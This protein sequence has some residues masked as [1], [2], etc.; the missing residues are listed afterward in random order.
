MRIYLATQRF[1]YQRLTVLT[2]QWSQNNLKEPLIWGN[3]NKCTL[4]RQN[5]TNV[6]QEIRS[7]FMMLPCKTMQLISLNKSDGQR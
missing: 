3:L 4:F 1:H 6:S 5:M 2:T 7:F